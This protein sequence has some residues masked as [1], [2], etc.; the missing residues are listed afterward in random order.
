MDKINAIK[1]IIFQVAVEFNKYHSAAE[2]D[3]KYFNE[4]N[5]FN[6]SKCLMLPYIITIANGKKNFFLNEDGIFKNSFLPIIARN[7]EKVVIGNLD[8]E[9]ILYNELSL[10]LKF[11]N[12]GNLI[13]DDNFF[14]Q[15]F[16]LD[17]DLIAIINYSIQFFI[18]RRYDDFAILNSAVLAK[19]TI[20][21]SA[22]EVIQKFIKS[23]N[24]Q[25]ES[26]IV[27]LFNIVIS[28][29]VYFTS[30]NDSLEE[31]FELED[32]HGD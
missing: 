9:F 3:I 16:N 27:K 20:Q 21:N 32:S 17:K 2:N 28:Q 29:S 18:A 22:F 10:D 24:I 31:K 8:V 5:N 26:I 13:L 12:D 23:K 30:F 25:E 6:L 7:N 15:T 19:L 11:N 14:N 4:H 1:Y